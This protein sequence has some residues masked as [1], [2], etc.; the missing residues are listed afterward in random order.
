MYTV[1]R[2]TDIRSSLMSEWFFL[3]KFASFGCRQ[4]VEG[5]GVTRVEEE[6]KV[7]K[8]EDPGE[9]SV[10]F[11]YKAHFGSLFLYQC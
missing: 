6:R 10:I 5:E 11:F 4:R 1:L 7:N 9:R 8:E 2:H 3:K